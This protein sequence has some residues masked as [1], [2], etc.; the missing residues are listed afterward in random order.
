MGLDAGERGVVGHAMKSKAL[1]WGL[2][3]ALYPPG[4]VLAVVGVTALWLVRLIVPAAPWRDA[5]EWF[6]E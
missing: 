6:L 5:D 3:L 1:F 2:L 4:F